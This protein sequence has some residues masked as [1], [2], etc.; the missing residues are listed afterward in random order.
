MISISGASLKIGKNEL[1]IALIVLSKS[2]H[3][4]P[5]ERQDIQINNSHQASFRMLIWSNDAEQRLNKSSKSLTRTGCS[6]SASAFLSKSGIQSPA[7]SLVGVWSN[8]V[9]VQNVILW[10]VCVRWATQIPTS[11]HLPRLPCVI[12][13]SI[14]SI[15]LTLLSVHMCYRLRCPC[16]NKKRYNNR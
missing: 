6:Q 3:F 10:C 7:Q 1:S 16:H 5:F 4:L 8:T 2:F 13:P 15:R 12:P 14:A 11:L 9:D